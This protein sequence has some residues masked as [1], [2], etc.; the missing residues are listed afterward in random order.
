M[1]Q[2]AKNGGTGARAK[3]GHRNLREQNDGREIRTIALDEKRAPLVLKTF[4]LYATGDYTGEQVHHVITAAGLTSRATKRTPEK[5]L[6]LK[7]TVRDAPG[8]VLPR[9][10]H[11]QG[12]RVQR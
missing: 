5:P 9:L 2:K 8:P 11:L 7:H 4:E 10:C 12:R 6:S 1:G 3:I